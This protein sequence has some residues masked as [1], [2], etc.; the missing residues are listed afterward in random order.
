MSI[1]DYQIDCDARG[2]SSSC[3]WVVQAPTIKIA[4]ERLSELDPK[5]MPV[6]VA[7]KEV[8]RLAPGA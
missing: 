6:R 4:L 3:Q 8:V 5:A 2:G 7:R 1:F